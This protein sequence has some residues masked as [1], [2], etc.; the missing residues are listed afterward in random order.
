VIED[1]VEAVKD[2]D[3]ESACEKLS[4]RAKRAFGVGVGLDAEGCPEIV[5]KALGAE[6]L[7]LPARDGDVTDIKV[8]GD[9]ATSKP[10]EPGGD[11][12]TNY[13]VE[14]D[15]EWKLD[16]P[17]EEEPEPEAEPSATPS[18]DEPEEP[19]VPELSVAEQGFT[20]TDAGTSYGLILDNP[21]TVSDALGVEVTIN[22]MGAN[23]DI[24][25]TASESL[26]GI[27]AGMTFA[28]GGEADTV[29]VD[30]IQVTT[31]VAR[32]GPPGDL[33]LPEATSPELVRD[34]DTLTVRVQ[35]ANMLA[36]PLS[37]SSAVFAV[38]RDKGGKIV[39]GVSGFPE[40]DIDP[41][42]SATI[43]LP[44]FD[45]LPSAASADAAADGNP[46]D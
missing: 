30:A 31:T 26:V 38:L 36:E 44:A 45:E 20:T 39:G 23:G 1:F 42:A 28:V 12:D 7:D 6:S 17:P 10:V 21:S 4:E 34:E 27:P 3:Y 37:T 41:G 11:D 32:A 46:S 43:E 18:P 9:H 33:K 5:E 15:G 8:D 14:E 40:A 2:K 35:V 24:L 25:V 16:V 29:D 19:E 22:L 13:Y